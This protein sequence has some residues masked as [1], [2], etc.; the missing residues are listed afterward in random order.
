MLLQLLTTSVAKALYPEKILIL[1]ALQ[2][3]I[4]DFIEVGAPTSKNLLFCIFFA[5]NCMKWKNLDPRGASYGAPLDP[6]M[7]YRQV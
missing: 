3:R 6:P 4:Q 7:F 2:W 5:E 1:F